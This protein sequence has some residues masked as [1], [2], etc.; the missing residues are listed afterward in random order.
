MKSLHKHKNK[1]I[2][3]NH[4]RPNYNIFVQLG[5]LYDTLTFTSA[6]LRRAVKVSCLC[7]TYLTGLIAEKNGGFRTIPFA[8]YRRFP[9]FRQPFQVIFAIP[10]RQN[11]PRTSFVQAF[12]FYFHSALLRT[13]KDKAREENLREFSDA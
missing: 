13:E 3:I 6:R 12:F 2:F 8:K 10:P 4:K 1:C 5:V 7:F 11:T 9:F